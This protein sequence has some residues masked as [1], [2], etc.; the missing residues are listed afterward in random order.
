MQRKGLHF[1]SQMELKNSIIFRDDAFMVCNTGGRLRLVVYDIPQVSSFRAFELY[2][3]GFRVVCLKCSSR[4]HFSDITTTAA[5]IIVNGR[6]QWNVIVSV[7]PIAFLMPSPHESFSYPLFLF[8]FS[9]N[10]W[11]I[12][13]S[14]LF[15]RVALALRYG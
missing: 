12:V 4:L 2:E 15:P 14:K 1:E 11:D 9:Y 8:C 13:L 7:L 3:N 5:Y 6:V 10:F